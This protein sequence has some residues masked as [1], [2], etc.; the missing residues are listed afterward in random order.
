MVSWLLKEIRASAQRHALQLAFIP[1]Y[2]L[3]FANHVI[4][5]VPTVMA[6]MSIT[7]YLVLRDNSS[8][9]INALLNVHQI[10]IPL[11]PRKHVI[12]LVPKILILTKKLNNANLVILKYVKL[13]QP[14]R[15]LVPVVMELCWVLKVNAFNQLNVLLELIQIL[16]QVFVVPV[17]IIVLLVQAL[18]KKIAQL[19]PL[20]DIN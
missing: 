2:R 12:I 10:L 15:L 3:I 1:T 8:L 18:L 17:I 14:P 7:V 19:V 6:L 16:K 5:L 4:T 9:I 11:L 13:A 20:I